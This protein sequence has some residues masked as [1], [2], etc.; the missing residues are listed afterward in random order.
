MVF[1]TTSTQANGLLCASAIKPP[2]KFS[3]LCAI[4]YA[5]LF[6]RVDWFCLHFISE[7][8]IIQNGLPDLNALSSGAAAAD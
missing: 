8:T 4:F 5:F 7:P 3:F 1:C 6:F 2:W